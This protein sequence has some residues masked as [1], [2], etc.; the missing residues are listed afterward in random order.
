MLTIDT[1]NSPNLTVLDAFWRAL[2]LSTRFNAFRRDLTLSDAFRRVLTFSNAFRRNF[3]IYFPKCYVELTKCEIVFSKCKVK[4]WKCKIVRNVWRNLVKSDTIWRVFAKFLSLQQWW[5]KVR[6][7]VWRDLTRSNAIRRDPTKFDA[8]WR[9][10]P[11][12]VKNAYS[13]QNSVKP[14]RVNFYFFEFLTEN[15]YCQNTQR[16][17]F[18]ITF[19]LGVKIRKLHFAI[20]VKEER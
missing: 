16:N 17:G 5:I 18:Q 10:F 12:N 2:T 7:S 15:I 3:T 1:Q 4:F 13:R 19:H 11:P 20:F 9:V 6:K 8:I 14:K